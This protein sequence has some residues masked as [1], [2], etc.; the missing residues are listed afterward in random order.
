MRKGV[1]LFAILLASISIAVI[2]LPPYDPPSIVGRVSRVIDGDTIE[3]SILQIP[4]TLADVLQVGTTVAVRYIGVD[5]P[6][7]ETPEGQIAT[8]LNRALVAGKKVYLELDEQVRDHYGRLLAYVYLDPY[9]YLMVNAILVSTCVISAYPPSAFSGTDR[10]DQCFMALDGTVPLCCESPSC[11]SWNQV[12]ENPDEYVGK[13]Y[14]VCGPV[15]SVYRTNYNRIFLNIGNP[16]RQNQVLPRFTVMID[17]A[18]TPAF[19]AEFGPNFEKKLQ[20]QFL[21]VYGEIKLYKGVPEIL[22]TSPNQLASEALGKKMPVQ[23]QDIQ[24]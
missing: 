24:Q 7:K 11:V 2:A 16:Y 1:V 18:Y 15:R 21:C 20:D 5:A 6:E 12:V 10:Y 19:D 3:V 22:P 14:W 17:E 9:G 23:C 4:E 13:T 8:S